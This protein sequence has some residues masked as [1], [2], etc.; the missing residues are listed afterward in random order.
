MSRR[1][2]DVGRSGAS[3]VVYYIYIYIYT[4]PYI[5]I[6][7]CLFSLRQTILFWRVL[8]FVT[9][10]NII[11]DSFTK[12]NKNRN[13]LSLLAPCH[14]YFLERVRASMSGEL[15]QSSQSRCERCGRAPGGG[16][17]NRPRANHQ[18]RHQSSFTRQR[19]LPE[20]QAGVVIRSIHDGRGPAAMIMPDCRA[21]AYRTRR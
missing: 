19:V 6:G 17:F 16:A 9:T 7:V 12:K 2:V 3:S 5:S 11:F 8:V 21:R 20:F 10:N 1:A 15:P 14:F 18:G 4:T 13:K